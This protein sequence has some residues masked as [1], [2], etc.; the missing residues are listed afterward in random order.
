MS[1]VSGL[2]GSGETNTASNQGTAGVGVFYQKS[3]EDLQFKNINAGSAKIT[4]TDDTSNNEIDINLGT[5][6]IDDLSDVDTTTNAPSSGQ[7]L[8]WDG[9]NFVPG[10]ASSNVSQLNDVTLTSLATGE[11]LQYSGSAWVNATLDTADITEH[12][13]NLY[14]TAR[15]DAILLKWWN[16]CIQCLEQYLLDRQ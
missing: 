8:K 13:S 2:S 4:V 12:S 6:S 15:V 9:S 1:S 14:Y 7:A 10:D 3:G 5:V 11:L 16:W